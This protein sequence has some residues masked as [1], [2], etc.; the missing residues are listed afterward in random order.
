MVINTKLF[1]HARAW[2]RQFPLERAVSLGSL[3]TDWNNIVLQDSKSS[4]SISYLHLFVFISTTT[5]QPHIHQVLVHSTKLFYN[6]FHSSS[7]ITFSFGF[8]NCDTLS[9]PFWSLSSP[10]QVS[11]VDISCL[12]INSKPLSL[13]FK[14]LINY[15]LEYKY[16]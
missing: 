10:V 14:I 4:P 7:F 3:M 11:T 12:Y 8:Y 2:V 5:E 15:I 1:L 16:L 9:F 6:S 13:I